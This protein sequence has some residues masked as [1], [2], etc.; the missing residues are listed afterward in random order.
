M[1]LAPQQTK[2]YD[3]IQSWNTDRNNLRFLLGGY[4]GTGKTTLLAHLIR[5]YQGVVHIVAPTGKAASVLG[6]KLEGLIPVRTIHS[7]IYTP[8]PPDSTVMEEAK[9]KMIENPDDRNLE[10]KYIKAKQDYDKKEVSFA[11]A[12]GNPLEPGQLIIVDE[13]SM[14]SDR[15]RADLERTGC[16]ILYVGDDGQLPPVNSKDWFKDSTFDF[17][18]TDVHRQALES[19]IIRMSMD[20]REGRVK[21]S[22]YKTRECRMVEQNV[23]KMSEL[24]GCDQIIVGKNVTRQKINRLIRHKLKLE[25]DLPVSGDKIICL[26][27]HTDKNTHVNFINGEQ[28]V[29]QDISSVF[30][31]TFIDMDYEGEMRYKVPVYDFHFK[32]NYNP[33]ENKLPWYETKGLREFD[34]AYAV[35]CHK[36]QG[37]EW[38]DVIVLDDKMNTMDR[39]FRKRWLYTAV[40]RASSN[41]TL[42]V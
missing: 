31:D 22:Q 38:D 27:N 35:T 30:G 17:H 20:I 8:I 42:T 9:Q 24:I 41:L 2:G 23:V 4:S 21:A 33:K 5:N 18:L 34:Y 13:A 40:T 14:V 39:E 1:K 3:L 37:S 36:S 7:L 28:G 6:R 15:T 32:H 11:Y 10:E 16:K 12:E 25:G 29:V 19:P 26:K